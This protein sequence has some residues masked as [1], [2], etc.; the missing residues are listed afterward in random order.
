MLAL[1]AGLATAIAIFGTAALVGV[2]FAKFVFW[3]IK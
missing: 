2:Y 3:L 1:I